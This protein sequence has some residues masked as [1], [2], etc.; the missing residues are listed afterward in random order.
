MICVDGTIAL[1]LLMKCSKSTRLEWTS[2]LST[3]SQNNLIYYDNEISDAE[4]YTL[5]NPYSLIIKNIVP[6]DSGKLNY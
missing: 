5:Q 3:E 2:G 4:K 1:Q 6:D